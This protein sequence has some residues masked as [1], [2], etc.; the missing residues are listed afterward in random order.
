MAL[1]HNLLTSAAAWPVSF[2]IVAGALGLAAAAAYAP[3]RV[4]CGPT[5]PA[6][7]NAS[8]DALNPVAAK[9]PANPA[10][11]PRLAAGLQPVQSLRRGLQPVQPVQP[12]CL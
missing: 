4:R 6:A 12:M 5:R 1:K 11:A 9:R 10:A 3:C 8:S 2:G 7:A